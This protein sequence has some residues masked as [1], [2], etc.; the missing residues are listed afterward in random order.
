M[1]KSLQGFSAS[2]AERVNWFLWRQ[3]SQLGV[4]SASAERRDGWALD[5]EALLLLSAT[6]ARCDPRLFDEIMDWLARNASFMNVPR[7]KSVTRRFGFQGQRVIGAM[8]AIVS[9]QN[10]RLNWRFPEP[11]RDGVAHPL[12]MRTDGTPLPEYG[13]PDPTFLRFG[14]SRGRVE[15]RGLSSRFDPLM[16]ECALLRLRALFGISARAE[17]LLYLLT[18]ES[19]HPSGI[20]RETGFSQKNVQDTL[21][22]MTAS[23]F[24]RSVRL[25][26]RKKSY[27]I[28]EADRARF[29]GNQ[30]RPPRWVTWPPLLRGMELLWAEMREIETRATS[31]LL[32]A[33]ELRRLADRL[34]PLAEQGGHVASL[35]DPAAHPGTAYADV[36]H[37]EVEYWLSLVLGERTAQSTA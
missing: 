23:G 35:S 32:L 19:G 20:A 3:W 5:P 14:F 25:E 17:I 31:D 6:F 15:V 27:L 2:L 33:S 1:G 36:F 7:L 28:P 21:V 8:A 37:E 22:D 12:F 9:A 16:P 10:T 34:R 29:L 24:V 26:G 13:E 11:T 30:E 4:A 18:H